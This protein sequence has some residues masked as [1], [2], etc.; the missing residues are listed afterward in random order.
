MNKRFKLFI[1]GLFIFF[2]TAL[3]GC[4]QIDTLKM[5]L[6]IKNND[7]E[8][9]KQGKVNKVIIQ[10]IRDKGFTFIITD[11]NSIKDL[12]DILSSAKEV[13]DKTYLE[14]DYIIEF[15]E[16]IDKIHKFKYIVGFDKKDAGNFYGDGKKYIVSN[17]LDDDILKNFWN[18]RVP[19]K[20]EEVYYGSIL[21]A[22][23]DYSKTLD[24][25]KKIGIDMTDEEVAKF[26]LTL[27]LEEF[28]EKLDD[29]AEII[30]NDNRNKYEI[31]MDISTYGYKTEIYKC[32]ITFFNKENKKETKY[33]FVNKYNL[34]SWTFNM[35]K[36]KEPENF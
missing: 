27:D 13:S 33:Y 6:G 23:E 3:V 10:N 18:L 32:I 30:Q 11:K 5:R 17:T 22:I 12:Y 31:T 20:F 8:Y 28:K 25:N 29:N 24:N 7:F 4:N 15:Y 26:I 14:P 35:T 1:I 34:N 2:S 19:K 16:S 36:D 21:K 9:I